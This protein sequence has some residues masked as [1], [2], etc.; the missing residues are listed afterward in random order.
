MINTRPEIEGRP[1][2]APPPPLLVS[3]SD[4]VSTGDLVSTSDPVSTGALVSTGARSTLLRKCFHGGPM[5]DVE[6]FPRRPFPRRYLGRS[7][8][9]VGPTQKLVST[10][11]LRSEVVSTGARWPEF[12]KC[13]HGGP[14]DTFSRL[15]STGA[16]WPPWKPTFGFHGGPIALCLAE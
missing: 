1:T 14:M 4:P 3:T 11:A 5:A 2:R 16:I 10:G 7:R 13:F 15:V 9:H 8:F 6:T 12:R